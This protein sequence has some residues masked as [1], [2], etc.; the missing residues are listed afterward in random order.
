MGSADRAGRISNPLGCHYLGIPERSGGPSSP[1]SRAASVI[2]M[3]HEG[4]QAYSATGALHV[5]EEGPC[6]SKKI[7]CF[8]EQIDRKHLH[9]LVLLPPSYI[10]DSFV[11]VIQVTQ[12]VYVVE[13]W[14]RN[15]N[16]RFDAESQSRRDVEKAF[17]AIKE[18][19][20]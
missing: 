4:S 1:N 16:S 14:V 19:K 20:T 13:E 9:S 6:H 2:P 3:G 5:I 11:I 7:F 15:A 17:G 12:Q 18:E 10:C 8:S